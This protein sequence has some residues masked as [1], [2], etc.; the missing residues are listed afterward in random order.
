MLISLGNAWRSGPARDL[1]YA[2]AYYEEAERLPSPGRDQ[3]ATLWK[4]TAD[5]LLAR[6]GSGDAARSLA[7]LERSLTIRDRGWLRAETLM[8]AARA[9]LAQDGDEGT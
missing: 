1:E 7:L 3:Q 8:S 9:E 6:A 4:V 2:L 5:A